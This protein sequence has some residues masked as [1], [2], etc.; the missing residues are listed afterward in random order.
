MNK[1]QEKKLLKSEYEIISKDFHFFAETKEE[2]WERI[3]KL[4][5]FED[6]INHFAD[7][8][9]DNN[10]DF[11]QF[12]DFSCGDDDLEEMRALNPD[13]NFDKSTPVQ[14]LLDLDYTEKFKALVVLKYRYFDLTWKIFYFE[15]YRCPG[16]NPSALIFDTNITNFDADLGVDLYAGDIENL[17]EE[18]LYKVYMNS[19]CD[20]QGKLSADLF[21]D[22]DE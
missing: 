13:V 2:L 7:L 18:T 10:D 21:F 9:V 4:G 22:R 1:E 15:V 14:Y 11:Y 16:S 12:M 17:T 19:N 8:N 6:A 3:L 5:C 20:R